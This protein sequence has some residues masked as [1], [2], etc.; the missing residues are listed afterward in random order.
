MEDKMT[1][2]K[3]KGKKI[4]YILVSVVGYAL[5]LMH[6]AD[7]LPYIYIK[8]FALVVLT[9]TFGMVICYLTFD[10]KGK[11]TFIDNWK[12]KIPDF[13]LV[14][15]S[16]LVCIYIVYDIDAFMMRLQ[17]RATT[18]DMIVG[19][20]AAI[21]VLE[22]C[23]RRTGLALPLIAVVSVAYALLG[24]YLPGVLQIKGYSLN[25]VARSIIGQLGIFGAPMTTVTNT[26]F[27]FLFF[28][29]F[30]NVCGA[31]EIFRDLSLAL[32]GK[33]RGGPAKMAVIASCIFGTISGS[34]ITNVVSTGAFT[35]PLMKKTGYDGTFAGAV[36]AVASTG[37]QIMPPVMG[38]AA[39]ILAEFTGIG[40]AKVCLAALVPAL[41]YFI[42]LFKTI[43]CEAMRLKLAGLSEEEIPNLLPVLK[44]AAKL[45]IPIVVLIVSLLVFGKT[46]AASAY[47]ATISIIVC[48][49]FNKVDR[50]NIKKLLQGFYDTAKSSTTILAACGCAG[51]I[52]AML[53]LTGLGLAFSNFIF[54]LGS[55]N[56]LLSL[57]FAMV[58]STILGTGLPTTVAYIITSTTMSS[59]FLLMGLDV[60]PA[61]MFLLYFASMSSITPP[62][63]IAAY[64]AAAISD[65]SPM[66][67]GLQSVRLGIVGFV[68]PYVF[69]YNQLILG[70]D[71]STLLSGLDTVQTLVAA[72]MLA[73]PLA[74]GVIGY[75]YKKLAW[76]HRLAYIVASV[77]LIVP[78][79]YINVPVMAVILF[80]ILRTSKLQKEHELSFVHAV[81]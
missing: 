15:G 69:I 66:K 32:A 42:F 71:F 30:L 81:A 33:K 20:V 10:F 21:T 62:V 13:L 2:E 19:L 64:T 12:A 50:F 44:R 6:I 75:T 31:N 68:V 65:S 46:P 40:Y 11:A 3:N 72:V 78:Y 47:Y 24:N 58:V 55:S 39:F 79:W 1:Q 67:V 60:L 63:A 14:V 23:R 74:Y 57:F 5:C 77:L 27:A 29:S 49:L 9:Y 26:V 38:A 76:W 4:Y 52:T 25:R 35:I 73:W 53:S 51:I 43:D 45:F 34:P 37:G 54:R 7:F 59:A 56:L 41:M 36:E 70:W 28:G 48:D 61:H 80:D 18:L 17:L 22:A 16:I 8:N